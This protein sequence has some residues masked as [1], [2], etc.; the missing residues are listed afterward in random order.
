M[1]RVESEAPALPRLLLSSEAR[2]MTELRPPPDRS[3]S[4]VRSMGAAS[5]AGESVTCC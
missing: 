4:G 2:V 3:V 5:F 1:G